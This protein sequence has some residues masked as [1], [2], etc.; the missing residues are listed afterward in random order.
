MMNRIAFL[1]VSS[2]KSCKSSKNHSDS[3]YLALCCW[4]VYLDYCH[5]EWFALETIRDH[6]VVFEI[7]PRYCL[8]KLSAEELN[9]GVEKTFERPLDC[10]ELQPVHPKEDQSWLFIGR[11]DAKAETP[12]LRPPHMKS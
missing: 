3:A 1:G 6:S 10:K 7:A 2:R 12:V 8:R 4:G 9:C 11:T 5:I